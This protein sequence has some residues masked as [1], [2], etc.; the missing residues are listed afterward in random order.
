MPKVKKIFS[1]RPENTKSPYLTK[2]KLASAARSGIRKAALDTM[3]VMGYIV[4]AEQDW[5]V[6]KYADG[7]VQKLEPIVKDESPLRID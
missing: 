2:R 1:K 6:K 4:V 5:I 7:T 3:R